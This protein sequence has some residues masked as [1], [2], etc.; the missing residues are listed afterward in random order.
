M[1]E[2]KDE[3]AN[4]QLDLEQILR[5]V[6]SI[7]RRL[8][9]SATDAFYLHLR[10]PDVDGAVED[11]AME[12]NMKPHE[13][14]LMK[15]AADQIVGSKRIAAAKKAFQ[16]EMTNLKKFKV[17]PRKNKC[18]AASAASTPR[19]LKPRST[20]RKDTSSSRS[21]RGAQPTAGK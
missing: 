2:L 3:I 11:L 4:L 7:A 14:L 1:A 18:S 21:L 12:Y 17:T 5:Q 9:D 6:Q 16:R 20:T 19:K 8:G 10:N 15:K 13:I